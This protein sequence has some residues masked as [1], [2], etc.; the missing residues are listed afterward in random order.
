MKW[1]TMPDLSHGLEIETGLALAGIVVA[2]VIS[3]IATLV[4]FL[5][6]KREGRRLA[7]RERRR[8]DR[9]LKALRES[10]ETVHRQNDEA[11]ERAIDSEPVRM[12]LAPSG[13]RASPS[14]ADGFGLGDEMGLTKR[15]QALKRLR[16][17]EPIETVACEVEAPLC[18]I[19]LLARVEERLSDA[20][21]R[22]KAERLNADQAVV[23]GGVTPG[24]SS[25]N[26][27]DDRSGDSDSHESSTDHLRRVA[28]PAPQRARSAKA[29]AGND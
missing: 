19:Q 11:L 15:A 10:L 21:E 9:E 5:S 18:E 14:I 13:D 3:L 6:V 7:L 1:L 26:P 22:R 29:G 4:L 24:V 28:I 17:G 25:K 27:V 20:R 12:L 8:T 2:L 16:A 23:T